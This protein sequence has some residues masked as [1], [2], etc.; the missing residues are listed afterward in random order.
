MCSSWSVLII[1]GPWAHMN[2]SEATYIYCWINV[3]IHVCEVGFIEFNEFVPVR[4]IDYMFVRPAVQ[5]QHSEVEIKTQS[6]N[7]NSLFY[8]PAEFMCH[9]QISQST[10]R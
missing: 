3:S 1:E 10:V 5:I 6:T 7:L 9:L 8:S 4:I 2:Q